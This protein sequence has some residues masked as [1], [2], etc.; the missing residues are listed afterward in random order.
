MGHNSTAAFEEG[1]TILQNVL[2]V[3]KWHFMNAIYE[4]EVEGGSKAGMAEASL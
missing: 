2:R 4:V 1:R 3:M